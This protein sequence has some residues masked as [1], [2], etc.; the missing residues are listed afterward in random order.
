MGKSCQYCPKPIDNYVMV[1]TVHDI[2]G[3]CSTA[4]SSRSPAGIMS[5]YRHHPVAVCSHHYEHLPGH[6]RHC[7]TDRGCWV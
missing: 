3:E 4:F 1:L 6:V 2:G 7:R 5:V